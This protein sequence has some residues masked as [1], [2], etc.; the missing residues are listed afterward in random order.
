MSYRTYTISH[1]QKEGF[2]LNLEE[3]S[4][5]RDA[6]YDTIDRVNH[7]VTGNRFLAGI[8]FIVCNKLGNWAWRAEKRISSI[9]LNAEQAVALSSPN[10]WDWLWESDN[11]R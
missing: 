6:V 5:I 11:E 2:L 7:A 4:W 10:A 8:G 9:P 3:H 1:S